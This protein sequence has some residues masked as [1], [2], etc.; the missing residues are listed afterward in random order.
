M[1]RPETTLNGRALRREA[2]QLGVI[3]VASLA[4][5]VFAGRIVQ[6]IAGVVD[7]FVFVM[8]S[9]AAVVAWRGGGRGAS[10]ALYAA[11]PAVFLTLALAN[12]LA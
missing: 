3:A 12:F 5:L 1:F 11:A 9:I 2:I 6:V 4:V 10:I 7:G 8:T